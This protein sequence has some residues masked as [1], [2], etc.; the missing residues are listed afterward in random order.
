MRTRTHVP[1]LE[2]AFP[3]RKARAQV[4]A[5]GVPKREGVIVAVEEEWPNFLP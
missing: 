5:D 4:A 1:T 3:E 2:P